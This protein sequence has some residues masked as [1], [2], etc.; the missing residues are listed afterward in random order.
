VLAGSD[1]AQ[2]LRF[3]YPGSGIAV[4]RFHQMTLKFLRGESPG[5]R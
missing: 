2:M 3:E 4:L 5:R 1:T